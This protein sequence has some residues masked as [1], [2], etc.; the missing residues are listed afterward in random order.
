M[1][2]V[3]SNYAFLLSR[4]LID[5]I[6]YIIIKIIRNQSRN[7]VFLIIE[8]FY[9]FKQINDQYFTSY[10]NQSIDLQCKS[11]DWLLYDEE[12]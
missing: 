2:R 4:L 3:T 1:F 10:R 9:C 5:T 6:T 12:H 8:I 7:L 11:I